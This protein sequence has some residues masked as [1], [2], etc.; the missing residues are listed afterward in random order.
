MI[1]SR[2]CISFH[3]VKLIL[4]PVALSAYFQV[5]FALGDS[6]NSQLRKADY[7]IDYDQRRIDLL[8]GTLD[9][10]I[11][12]NDPVTTAY[13]GKVYFKLIDSL[14]RLIDNPA[15]DEARKK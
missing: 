8:D 2:Y 3:R 6:T 12:L 4:V 14:Q 5:A 9:G 13:A 10:K 7:Y 11:D 1:F 15:F